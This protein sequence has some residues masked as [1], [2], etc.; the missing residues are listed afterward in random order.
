[1]KNSILLFILV[2]SLGAFAWVPGGSPDFSCRKKFFN[3]QILLS[4]IPTL[5]QEDNSSAKVSE[6][7]YT[8]SQIVGYA[9][10]NTPYND[11]GVNYAGVTK[12]PLNNQSKEL[13]EQM[14]CLQTP[15]TNSLKMI[16]VTSAHHSNFRYYFASL[17]MYSAEEK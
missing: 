1:M 11:L 15:Q 2:F 14:G 4:T 3:H 10:E 9:C 16:H 12:R 8:C 6:G 5:L 13:L 7:E 17:Q